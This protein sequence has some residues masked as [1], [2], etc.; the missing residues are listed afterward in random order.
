MATLSRRGVLAATPAALLA[1]CEPKIPMTVSATPPLDIEELGRAAESIA[2][3]VAPGVMGVG[4]MNLESGQSYLLNDDRPFP[5]AGMAMLPI[6]AAVLAEAD[7]GRLSL[8]EP[9]SVLEEQLSPGVSAVA[10]AWPGR[11]DYTAMGLLEAAT[12]QDD[13]TARDVLLKRIGGPGAVT[14]WLASK[15]L[16][17]LRVDS[18]ARDQLTRA[19]G[20]PSARPAWRAPAAFA[21]A[22]DAVPTQ[23]RLAAAR[24][25]MRSDQDSAT[26]RGLLEF[27]QR[28]DRQELL[29]PASTQRLLRL[30]RRTRPGP[31]RAGLPETAFLAHQ[32]ARLGPVQGLTL[33]HHDAGLATLADGR[34]YA[35]VTLV[36]GAT[37][38]LAAQDALTADLARAAILAAG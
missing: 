13:S 9:L 8:D 36:S 4:V 28:L 3:R 15:R 22:R 34:V 31:L 20:M 30:L 18:Y 23:Q 32:P 29:T 6:A 27:F 17:G 14:A 11:R 2:A 16:I 7:S 35:I 5:M 25:F 10:A 33:A 26:P 37:S 12:T 19:Y 21:A 1:A 38:A 24:A